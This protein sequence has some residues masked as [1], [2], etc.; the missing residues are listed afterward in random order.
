MVAADSG[1]KSDDSQIEAKRYNRIDDPIIHDSVGVVPLAYTPGSEFRWA[2]EKTRDWDKNTIFNTRDH[3]ELSWDYIRDN[4]QNPKFDQLSKVKAATEKYMATHDSLNQGKYL[5]MLIELGMYKKLGE[6][7][8][9]KTEGSGDKSIL[10]T[11]DTRKKVIRI[12]DYLTWLQC[13]YDIELKTSIT[14]DVQAPIEKDFCTG[15]KLE[16]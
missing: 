7:N 1:M 16:Y 2:S 12:H 11:A 13:H 8:D 5:E 10:I 4:F 3:L 14:Y 6:Y 15:T 9:I